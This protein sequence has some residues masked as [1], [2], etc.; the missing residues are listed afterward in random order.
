MDY[1]EFQTQNAANM[2]KQR[3]HSSKFKKKPSDYCNEYF[4]RLA[5][6]HPFLDD[7][8]IKHNLKEELEEFGIIH[9]TIEIELKDE[10]CHDKNCEVKTNHEHHHHH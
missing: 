5:K 3:K 2:I 1:E 7:K 10:K 4:A 6:T 8:D 9:S